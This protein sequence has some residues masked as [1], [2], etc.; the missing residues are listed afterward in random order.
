MRKLAQAI[1]LFHPIKI[2]TQPIKL[3]RRPFYKFTD[4]ENPQVNGESKPDQPQ[5]DQKLS[6]NALKK[7]QKA[8]QK[9]KEKAEKEQ[10]KPKAENQKEEEITD[11]QEYYKNRCA[12]V[13]KL[14]QSSDFFPY[15]HKFQITHLIPKLKD[16]YETK[17]AE[18]GVF[19]DD[20]IAVAGRVHS[21]R[22]SGKNLVFY[23]LKAEG[24]KIQIM[25][26]SNQY[27]DEKHFNEIKHIIKRGDIIGVKG[28]I[29]RSKTG[30]L[31]IAPKFL[32][33]L[34]PCLHMLPKNVDKKDENT[35]EALTDQETRYR[36]RYLD[37]IVNSKP[38]NIFITR[39]KVIQ[40]LRQE[41]TQRDF[42]EVE[43]PVLNIL[44]GGATARPFETYHKE[45]DRK[46]FLRIAPELYLKTCVVGGIDRVYE[47][48]KQFRNE[49]IDHTHNPEFTSCELYWAYADYEDLI[50]FTEEVLCS[51]IQKVKGSLKFDITDDFGNKVPVDF[52][53]P[54][55]RISMME[56][57]EKVLN[58]PI[59]ENL[60]SD[61]AHAFFDEM[62][63]KHNVICSE[64]RTTT[65]LI[66]KLVGHFIEPNCV[67]PT[68]LTE[69]PQ[70]M[71]PLAKYHRS[72]KGLTER[73]ELFINRKEF[74]NAYTELND[75]FIQMEQFQLQVK[76]KELGNDEASPVD[77]DFVKCLEHALPPTGGWGLGVDRFIMLLT[78]SVNIQEVIL[79][80]AMK[81]KEDKVQS[82]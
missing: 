30:E 63:K 55:K 45:L 53:R 82:N 21:I 25:A 4:M 42:L 13:E 71:C 26:N 74:V 61:E 58:C 1:K 80:P 57:L 14:K 50:T 73:F 29:G 24:A 47:I 78:D 65:R 31:S 8:E 19:L 9:A 11:P 81:P 5:G 38:K 20:E 44:A 32:Q 60:E 43:T 46:M 48:G 33:L 79:F 39:S 64:P 59:P 36:Q 40:Y 3:T 41:F 52:S 34:S 54:W 68:F 56:E 28:T 15:P 66:D 17:C 35:K 72:K 27:G 49:G 16:E 75:P 22:A 70:I 6:K 67:N 51:I 23:D 37:L 69:Q 62:C 10:A 77:E 12:M 18:N 7:L 76:E 2:P